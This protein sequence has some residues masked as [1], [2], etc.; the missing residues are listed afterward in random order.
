MYGYVLTLTGYLSP[1]CSGERRRRLTRTIWR[2]KARIQREIDIHDTTPLAAIL[3]QTDSPSSGTGTPR[4]LSSRLARCRRTR[5]TRADAPGRRDRRRAPSLC[6]LPAA[7]CRGCHAACRRAARHSRHVARRQRAT[8][9]PA[10]SCRGQRREESRA[11]ATRHPSP[12]PCRG[13][14]R[15]GR[16]ARVSAREQRRVRWTAARWEWRLLI[17][18]A[19][20]RGRDDYYNMVSGKVLYQRLLYVILRRSGTKKTRE[21]SLTPRGRSPKVFGK[22][23]RNQSIWKV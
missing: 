13:R 12:A 3:S 14:K 15:E 11:R 7:P 6:R 1:L 17:A 10:A 4:P 22:K 9:R 18:A 21:R 5:R 23:G 20:A 19:A 8:R 16:R 2:A